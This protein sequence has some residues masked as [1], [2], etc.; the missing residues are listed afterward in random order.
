MTTEVDKAPAA[1]EGDSENEEKL[2]I[3]PFKFYLQPKVFFKIVDT[4]WG[5]FCLIAGLIY[6]YHFFWTI[7]GVNMYADYTRL[8]T[9][10]G[11]SNEEASAIFDGAL[12][13]STVW[14]L[15]E[16]LRWTLF[17]TTALV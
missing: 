16:W 4:C 12:L 14:H 10:A 5:Q 6:I 17:L 2:S 15:I 7:A 9:C 1:N 13:V 8:N 11:V 3:Q